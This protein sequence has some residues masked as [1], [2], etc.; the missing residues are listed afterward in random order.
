[1]FELRQFAPLR[2]I[3]IQLE[4]YYFLRM[5]RRE[6]MLLL[7]LIVHTYLVLVDT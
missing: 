4:R 1:M 3:T 5:A 7:A 2:D 6:G